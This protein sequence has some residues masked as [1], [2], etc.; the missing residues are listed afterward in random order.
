MGTEA[1]R[2]RCAGRETLSTKVDG[3]TR[4]WV[5]ERA[6]ESGVTPT[7]LVRRLIDLYRVSREDELTC[8]YCDR[9]LR[10]DREVAL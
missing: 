7:E 2:S 9:G 5:E 4:R 3:E 8:P 10:L 1:I 6:E